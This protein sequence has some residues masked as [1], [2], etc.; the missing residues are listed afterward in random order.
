MSKLDAMLRLYLSIFISVVAVSTQN[1]LFIFLSSVIIY[2][3]IT[4][5]CFLYSIFKHNANMGLREY[6][7]TLV[8]R[9]NPSAFFVF[10][11]KGEI[12]FSNQIAKRQ[13]ETIENIKDLNINIEDY[14][15]LIENNQALKYTYENETETIEINLKGNKEAEYIFAYFTNLIE[16]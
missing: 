14:L 11:T 2:T 12:M 6:Y 8:L 5:R 1:Y 3:A 16:T 9:N 15:Y 4:R 10:D 7:K 13:Y